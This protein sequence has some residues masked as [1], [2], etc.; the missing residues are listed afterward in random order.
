MSIA[1]V[2]PLAAVAALAAG[3][4]GGG[5]KSEEDRAGD[6]AKEYVAT[7]ANNEREKCVDT[8]A[9]GVDPKLCDDLGPLASRINPEQKEAKVT[10]NTALVTVTGAGNNTRIDVSLVKEDGEWRVKS[11]K[12]RAV[13]PS[14]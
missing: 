13:P 9:D 12:G 11:W 1:R 14:S 3:C 7:H 8:L 4:G 6:V 2:I 10:G 5:E